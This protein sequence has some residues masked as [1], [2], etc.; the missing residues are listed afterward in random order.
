MHN[1]IIEA[2]FC[3][4]LLWQFRNS[5]VLCFVTLRWIEFWFLSLSCVS[6]S[7]KIDLI[8]NCLRMIQI[9]QKYISLE[10][11]FVSSWSTQHS[12]FCKCIEYVM[13]SSCDIGRRWE[14]KSQKKRRNTFIK[15]HLMLACVAFAPLYVSWNN[16]KP[17]TWIEC[18]R[19]FY[20]M[21]QF[22]AQWNFCHKLCFASKHQAFIT[23]VAKVIFR[24]G[25]F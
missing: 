13:N 3:S 6:L 18:T 9:S 23:W 25:Q 2:C 7:L 21:L 8:W 24:R 16:H 19:N 1:C 15:L 20:A 12:N 4:K 14:M 22:S 10:L 5:C 17:S 11:C